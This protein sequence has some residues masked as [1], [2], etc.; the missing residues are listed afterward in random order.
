[1]GMESKIDDFIFDLTSDISAISELLADL[2]EY[3]DECLMN[4]IHAIS[5]LADH[6]ISLLENWQFS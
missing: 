6:Q 3:A 2:E 1:M 5:V 4:K